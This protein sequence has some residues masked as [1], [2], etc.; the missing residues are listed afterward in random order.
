[1]AIP[2]RTTLSITLLT[3]AVAAHASVQVIAPPA[4][5]VYETPVP[6][7]R[8]AVQ[9]VMQPVVQQDQ[10]EPIRA[11]EIP[12]HRQEPPQINDAEG[13]LKLIERSTQAIEVFQ[14]DVSYTRVFGLAGD[15]QER[16]GRLVFENRRR[17]G[18]VNRRFY[19]ELTEKVLGTQRIPEIQRYVFDGRYLA[20]VIPAEFQV[21]IRELAREGE[22]F[23]PL[24]PEQGLFVVPVGQR[25]ADVL[26]TFD[27]ELVDNTE[28]LEP[29]SAVVKMQV[30]ALQPRQLK[31]TPKPGKK[32]AEEFDE[33]RVWYDVRDP[34][35]V[36][37][38]FVRTFDTDGDETR[39]LFQNR[40]M[41]GQV[42]EDLFQIPTTPPDGR[43]DM[44][45]YRLPPLRPIT[46]TPKPL[47]T[48]E[49]PR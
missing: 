35:R 36:T 1:M 29:F 34:Q 49:P 47:P 15:E 31:L 26:E 8:P 5:E 10:P 20:E 7:A 42:N 21:N 14:A 41:D 44:K 23:D 2:R 27:A 25:S 17:A 18:A 28:A 39:V 9:P 12:D 19:I 37:P 11:V 30:D 32:A 13:L 33:I 38:L 3:A 4:V 16:R 24:S 45:L 46:N 6:V 22:T 40:V 48:E 43:W